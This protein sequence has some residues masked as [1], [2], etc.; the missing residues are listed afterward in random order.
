MSVKITCVYDEGSQPYTSLIGAKGTSFLVEKDGKKVLFNTGLRDRYLIHNMEF[1]EIDPESIDAV[2]VSQ[3]NPSDA[4]ALN[5]FLKIR[6]TPINV[7]APKGLYGTKSL[8]SRGVGLAESNAPKANFI[9]LGGWEEVLPGIHIT[10]FIYDEKG[11]GETFMVV[12][13]G[14]KLIIL[15]GRCSCGPEKF[16]S[17]VKD[18]FDRTISAFIGPVFLEKKKKPVAEQYANVLKEIPD[19]YLNH[20]TGRDGMTNLR[21]HLGLAGVSD[22]YVGD[23]YPPNN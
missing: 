3:S 6:E 14:S 9:E 22:F 16:I 20:C 11:Y 5:G 17:A 21:V 12:E 23:T 19:L 8:L 2:V 10:P 7:Y 18:H 13:N 4:G 15:S 1:L